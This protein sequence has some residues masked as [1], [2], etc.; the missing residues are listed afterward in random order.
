MAQAFSKGKPTDLRLSDLQKVLLG[1]VSIVGLWLG[2]PNDV[3]H[4]PFL[5]LLFPLVLVGLAANV[6]SGGE[7]FKIG[8]LVGLLGN[9]IGLY[10]LTLPV[11]EVGG[12]P[13]ALAVPCTLFI[14]AYVGAYGGIFALAS[15][16]FGKAMPQYPLQ[17]VLALACLWYGL[18]LVRSVAFTGFPWLSLS[19]AFASFP[20]MIQGASVVG[21][22]GLSAL[23]VAVGLC[24]L[25]SVYP[26][27][28]PYSV[29]QR[30]TIGG[31]GGA[32]LALILALGFYTLHT[33]PLM[34]LDAKSKDAFTVIMVEGNVDQNIKWEA[35]NQRATVKLYEDLSRHALMSLRQKDAAAQPLLIW[36]ETAMPFYLDAHPELGRRVI[37]FV[38]ELQTPLLVGAPA[39]HRD[40]RGVNMP[41]NRAY[42]L[43]SNGTLG[44]Y[45]DKVHLVPFGEYVPSWLKWNFLEALLQ[46]IGTFTP[47]TQTKPVQHEA[48]ALGVLICYEGI[49]PDLAQER[50][51]AGANVL[52][53]IS[54]DG[55]FGD[56]PAPKQHLDMAIMRAV[57]QGRWLVRSTNTGI[58]AIVDNFGRVRLQGAQ[59]KEQAL[60]GMAKIE[61]G[62]TF[63]H[64]LYGFIPVFFL[65]IFLCCLYPLPR[66]QKI[67]FGK[68]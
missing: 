64:K 42:L 24:I 28:A 55:W 54:N 22:F 15:Y 45:Y 61:S 11:M 37:N 39:M 7:A 58:S 18:E 48:L 52:I 35:H 23:F 41:F 27:Y 13:W 6:Q 57:E 2:Y 30:V 60:T 59:F 19:S 4:V 67:F 44:G 53:N 5:V 51:D 38:R 31:I 12:L 14:A 9:A 47:G 1:I 17:R 29:K 46:G 3:A 16:H 49:F 40:A 32:L 33:Y 21:A 56:S 62:K 10:W 50:V 8:W 68:G 34:A 65:V 26:L 25:E 43:R 36:P 66:V 63:F 20:F